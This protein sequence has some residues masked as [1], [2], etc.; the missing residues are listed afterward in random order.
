MPCAHADTG[1]T[2]CQVWAT[3]Y[4]AVATDLANGFSP[5]KEMDE[6]KSS[7]DSNH[8][9]QSMRVLWIAAVRDVYSHPTVQP[10][11]WFGFVLARCEATP[12]VSDFIII[13]APTE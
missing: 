2:E 11:V 8:A 9:S 6:L 5:Q 12:P 4:F 7:L 1:F 10:Q 13:K 3:A